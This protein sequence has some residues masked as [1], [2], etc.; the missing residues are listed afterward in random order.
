[1][2]FWLRTGGKPLYIN[3]R[4]PISAMYKCRERDKMFVEREINY[5]CY[6]LKIWSRDWR[7][8]E[9]IYIYICNYTQISGSQVMVCNNLFGF[10][11]ILILI[12]CCA[13]GFLK[14]VILAMEKS[15]FVNKHMDCFQSF[16]IFVGIKTGDWGLVVRS[17]VERSD[18]NHP[19]GSSEETE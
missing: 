5:L 13:F 9:A 8:D 17:P 7:S 16:A 10:R 12:S 6:F 14:Q 18:Q 2:T 1:M 4:L 19:G 11:D 15:I 3:Q